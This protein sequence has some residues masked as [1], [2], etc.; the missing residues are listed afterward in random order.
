MPR[1]LIAGDIN[2][3]KINE[4][5]FSRGDADAIL[6]D[7]KTVFEDADLVIANLEA[8]LVDK[9]TP[10]AKSGSVLGVPSECIA[11][12]TEIG[13]DIL[14]LANNHTMDHGN[15]GLSNTL[16]VAH[17]AG[18][19]CVGAGKDL[20]EASRILVREVA[21]H[22]I[23]IL[24]LA[25]H[26]FGIATRTSSGV[27]PFD[28]VVFGRA[29]ATHKDSYDSL[30]VL[31]HGG[32]EYYRYP[33]PSLQQACR[34]LVELGA[35]I[36]SCQHSHIV[37]CYEEYRGGHIIYGQG[38]FI[39]SGENKPSSW[40]EG[41]LVS[42]DLDNNG[43]RVESI[44]VVQSESGNPGAMRMQGRRLAEFQSEFRSRNTEVLDPSIVDARW[45]EFCSRKRNEYL[46]RYGA[47]HRAFRLLDRV[48]GYIRFLLGR[49]RMRLDHLN[50]LQC[51]SHRE[52]LINVL[53]R[54]QISDSVTFRA[55]YG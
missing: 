6:G 34:Y 22:R 25:E 8:P 15:Q 4:D 45:D 46:R 3:H 24:A 31:L 48:T 33:R 47:L 44:P 40:H 36:V 35:D 55:R 43:V 26:E 14:G 27:C 20:D 9:Q 39:C 17:A 51:E 37:G 42:V 2:S 53:S 21:E 7:L 28:P 38:N 11:G 30:I 5:V 1:V 16:A 52:V 10:V 13:I 19:E 41:L 23:G 50:L 18:I 49:N 32:N 54:D 12:F 29:I